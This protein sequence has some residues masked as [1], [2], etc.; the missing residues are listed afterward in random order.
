MLVAVLSGFAASLAAPWVYRIGR[1]LTILILALV[2][3]L[4]LLRQ[5]DRASEKES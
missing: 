4:R 5:Q 3:C 2:V 1:G